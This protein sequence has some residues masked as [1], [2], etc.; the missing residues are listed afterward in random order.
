M[1]HDKGPNIQTK[2]SRMPKLTDNGALFFRGFAGEF[3]GMDAAVLTGAC[4][5]PASFI[6]ASIVPGEHG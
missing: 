3:S 5:T 6:A 4:T 1:P 2:T